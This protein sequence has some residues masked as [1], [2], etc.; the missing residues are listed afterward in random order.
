MSIAN[1]AYPKATPAHTSCGAAG[2]NS[3]ATSGGAAGA[4]TVR[5]HARRK[6]PV[7]NLPCALTNIH[8]L[9]IKH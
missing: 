4:G 6:I 5:G 1:P 8:G 2:S 9:G 3:P 7:K